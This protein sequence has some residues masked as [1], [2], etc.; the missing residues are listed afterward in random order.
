MRRR[1]QSDCDI[2]M[3][4]FSS[5]GSSLEGCFNT[6][7]DERQ[8]KMKKAGSLLGVLGSTGKLL[9]HGGSYAVKKTP[10]AIATV[11]SVKREVTETIVNEYQQYQKELK[12]QELEDKIKLLKK[13]RK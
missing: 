3:D 5:L 11:A 7:L 9:F 8:S 10:K 2:I 12:K 6:L 1:K 13:R 4:D